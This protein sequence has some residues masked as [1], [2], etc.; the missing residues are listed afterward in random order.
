MMIV[1]TSAGG[2]PYG[3]EARACAAPAATR[4]GGRNGTVDRIASTSIESLDPTAIC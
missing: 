4:P 2:C 3:I 1:P